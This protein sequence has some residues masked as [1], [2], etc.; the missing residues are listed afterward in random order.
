MSC[1]LRLIATAGLAFAMASALYAYD[2]I[3]P[4][5]KAASYHL[6]AAA[7]TSADSRF[8]PPLSLTTWAFPAEP[9]PAGAAH[10]PPGTIRIPSSQVRIVPRLLL[11]ARHAHLAE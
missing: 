2:T 4:K 9:R 11:L 3:T 8:V 1:A 10:P 7:D 6:A 5:A